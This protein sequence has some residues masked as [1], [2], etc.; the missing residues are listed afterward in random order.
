[1]DPR[2][3]F[4]NDS[5]LTIRSV[6]RVL[7]R[8][9]AEG[10][11]Y[12]GKY[13]GGFGI[14]AENNEEVRKSEPDTTVRTERF[15]DFL[16]ELST[17]EVGSVQSSVSMNL[18]TENGSVGFSL[19]FVPISETSFRMT[20]STGEQEIDSGIEFYAMIELMT[21]LFEQEEFSYGALQGEHEPLLDDDPSRMDPPMAAPAP[22]YSEEVADRIGRQD[23]LDAPSTETREL[24]SGG[25]PLITSSQPRGSIE[26]YRA[27]RN[28]FGYE[29][30]PEEDWWGS[31]VY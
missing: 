18:P 12:G 1:M 10:V 2:Y 14:I 29:H 31:E 23:L 20:G 5:E 9:T 4:I 27:F 3:T 28:H 16:A 26:G 17:F 24:D 13:P 15:G 19:G 22:W 30:P 7:F 11:T 25:I 8:C 6:A 21:T